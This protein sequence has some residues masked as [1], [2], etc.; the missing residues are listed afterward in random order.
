MKKNLF[1]VA[2]FIICAGNNNIAAQ[3]KKPVY[4]GMFNAAMLY[5]ANK[6]EPQLQTIHGIKYGGWFAGFG[7]GIDDYF[8][9]SI[10]IFLDIRKNIFNKLNTPF[11]YVEAGA[12]I[13]NKGKTDEWQK[14]KMNS[15]YFTESGLGYS[16]DIGK[17][18]ILN[19]ACAYSFKSY[20][21]RFY[22]KQTIP[23]PPYQTDKWTLVNENKYSLNRLVMKVGLQF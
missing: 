18:L 9:H 19:V 20:E 2:I 3:H 23:T 13:V 6:T 16:V 21:E 8:E 4:A 10:P 11:V 17:N 14:T 7:G 12:N 15:G 5:G 22:S 1:C